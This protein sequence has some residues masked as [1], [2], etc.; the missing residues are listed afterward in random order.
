MHR[1]VRVRLRLRVGAV[2]TGC[3]QAHRFRCGRRRGRRP[4]S[5][6]TRLRAGFARNAGFRAA[7]RDPQHGWGR[8][9]CRED[10][11]AAL[12]ERSA[13]PLPGHEPPLPEQAGR[14]D[15]ARARRRDALE[16]AHDGVSRLGRAR[17]CA[18]QDG[19]GYSR[20]IEE[21]PDFCELRHLVHTQQRSDQHR[22]AGTRPRRRREKTA[23]CGIQLGVKRTAP[24]RTRGRA[25]HTHIGDP[26]APACRASPASLG[27]VTGASRGR[28]RPGAYVALDGHRRDAAALARS[29]RSS[30]LERG[31]RSLL[32]RHGCACNENRV[33]EESAA[34][35][36]LV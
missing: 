30:G 2:A 18:I 4:R 25:L 33:V 17:R 19:D 29:L 13:R 21:R 9:E 1:R 32:G 16:P 36:W 8:R 26:A 31:R 12:Q 3:R 6:G 22:C 10:A 28:A 14:N 7:D 23:H 35:A 34:H 20:Q 5:R 11:R 27:F 24:G 15:P